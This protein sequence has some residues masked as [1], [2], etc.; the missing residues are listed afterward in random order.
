MI[1]YSYRQTHPPAKGK[2]YFAYP[3]TFFQIF[4]KILHPIVYV[5]RLT[6]SYRDPTVNLEGGGIPL[7]IKSIN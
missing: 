4:F 1:N 6:T 3:K 7:T 2:I 5:D